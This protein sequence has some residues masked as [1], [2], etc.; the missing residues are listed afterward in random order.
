MRIEDKKK[1]CPASDI[2]I[3]ACFEYDGDVC[4][5]LSD[6]TIPGVRIGRLS[7][8]KVST[9]SFTMKVRPINAKVVVE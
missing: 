3:G 7:N 5:R 4:I 6:G 9:I 2:D 8:G 1:C